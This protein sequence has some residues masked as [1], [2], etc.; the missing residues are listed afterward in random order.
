VRLVALEV[1][2]GEDCI[3]VKLV[4]GEA[5]VEVIVGVAQHAE[6]VAGSLQLGER[7]RRVGEQWRG[8]VRLPTR[9]GVADAAGRRSPSEG[10]CRGLWSIDDDFRP[11]GFG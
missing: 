7:G 4:Q 8:G 1:L 2:A 11:R 6:A 3:E 10:R 9:F 5:L